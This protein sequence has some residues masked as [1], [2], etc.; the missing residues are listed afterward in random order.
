MSPLSVFLLECALLIALPAIAWRYLGLRRIAPL[1]MIQIAIGLALGP[2]VLGRVMP[3]VEAFLFPPGNIPRLDGIATLAVAVFAFVS[4]MRLD[5]GMVRNGH[6]H[7]LVIAA[8]GFLA[9]LILGSGL[10][11]WLAVG[12]PGLIGHHA[13]AWQFAC[14]FGVCLA[15]TALPVLA[16][17]LVE[18]GMAQSALGQRALAYSAMNDAIMWITLFLLVTAAA[19][20]QV[21][22]SWHFALILAYLTVTLLVSPR[23][24]PWLAARRPATGKEGGIDDTTLVVACA[25]ALCSALVA[26]YI[27]LDYIL[28]AFLSGVSMPARIRTS[29]IQKLDWTT[30]LVLMPFFYMTTGLKIQA[31]LV[32]LPLLAIV[33]AATAAAVIG[34]IL[35]IAVPAILL[36]EPWRQSLALGALLQSKGLMEVLVITALTDAGIVGPEVF[37][38]IILVAI[39]CTVAARPLAGIFLGK[40]GLDRAMRQALPADRSWQ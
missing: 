12:D 10:G 39:I 28:G 25:L 40:T 37:S 22:L 9:P 6:P 34:K 15:V 30:M 31:D 18:M 21:S 32:S 2:S 7:S 35:G 13:S 23:L 29:L 17:L 3:G 5:D 4:G 8:G 20:T 26:E 14:G 38:V 36:G 11:Y 1:A 24:M 19:G 16:S 33:T 27:G